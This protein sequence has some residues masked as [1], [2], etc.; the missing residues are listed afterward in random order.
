MCAIVCMY[1]YS[2]PLHLVLH[3]HTHTHTR[4][5]V[6]RTR[7]T[8]DTAHDEDSWGGD[9]AADKEGVGDSVHQDHAWVAHHME[10]CLEAQERETSISNWSR[11]TR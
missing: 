8:M 2:T 3:T 6:L 7:L 5:I 11:G 10:A 4:V 1:M 9:M